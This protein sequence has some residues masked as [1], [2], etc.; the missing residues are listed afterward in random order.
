MRNRTT[1]SFD[2]LRQIVRR[3]PLGDLLPAL[4]ELT[5]V[6]AREPASRTD[7]QLAIPSLG[8]CDRCTR[9]GALGQRLPARHCR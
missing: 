8:N 6:E 5:L 7:L 2:E 4:A 9:V 1:I 3:Y